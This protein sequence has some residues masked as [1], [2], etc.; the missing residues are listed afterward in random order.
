MITRTRG[1]RQ[2]VTLMELLAV[3]ILMGILAVVGIARFGRSASANFGSNGE[4]RMLS[5]S[6]LRARRLAITTGDNHFIQFDAAA[7]TAATQYN[8]MQRTGS[9]D[10]LVEGPHL[11]NSDV[12][13]VASE[14]EMDFTF[15]GE[16]DGAY[17][18]DFDGNGRSWQLNVV[19]IT[20][21]VSVAEVTP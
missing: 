20:G 19:P 18:V 12:T 7:P 14:A 11:L 1:R 13:V 6:M 21:A 4:A 5:L 3:V 8:V 15:E 9:G 16:A 10:V 17:Q 2:G